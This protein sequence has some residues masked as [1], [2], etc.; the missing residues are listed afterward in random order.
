MRYDAT[1]VKS[2]SILHKRYMILTCTQ[3]CKAHLHEE[4]KGTV[5]NIVMKGGEKDDVK[6]KEDVLVRSCLS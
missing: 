2:M 1:H 5:D 6:E 4:N 3:H